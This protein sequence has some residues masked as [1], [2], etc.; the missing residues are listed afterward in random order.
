MSP[1][2][3]AIDRVKRQFSSG[4]DT[5]V[6]RASVRDDDMSLILSAI[7]NIE[8]NLSPWISQETMA[9]TD[10]FIADLQSHHNDICLFG[11]THMTRLIG[12][13]E[14]DDDCYYRVSGMNG[15][16]TRLMSCVG[17]LASLKDNLTAELYNDIEHS[18]S[19]NGSES[20]DKFEISKFLNY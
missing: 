20:T 6:D 4:N 17:G 3:E 19:L 10:K 8:N 18:F 9:G 7:P 1:L 2:K 12:Y 14:D 5:A 13:Y 11:G 15:D 16:K